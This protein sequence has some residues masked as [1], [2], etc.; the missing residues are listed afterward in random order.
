MFTREYTAALLGQPLPPYKGYNPN[1]RASCD[2][3]FAN[4]AFRYG[5][6]EINSFVARLDESFNEDKSGFMALKGS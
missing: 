6:A 1:I 3:F 4:C 2:N 5:H